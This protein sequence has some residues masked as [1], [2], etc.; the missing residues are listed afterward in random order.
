MEHIDPFVGLDT[1]VSLVPH[2]ELDQLDV[3]MEG[4]EVQG[5]EPLLRR[6]R[7]VDPVCYL[8]PD[9]LLD[10]I[11]DVDTELFGTCLPIPLHG[12]IL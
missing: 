7:C 6:R 3:A 9:L 5:V 1:E 12:D 8:G 10:I 11:N 4:R 2:Q